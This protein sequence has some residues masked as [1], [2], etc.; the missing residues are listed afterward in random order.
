MLMTASLLLTACGGGEVGDA[1]ATSP[2]AA[3]NDTPAASNDTPT[4][5]DDDAGDEEAPAVA[6]PTAT[7]TLVERIPDLLVIHPDAFDF[8][9]SAV[10]DT[11]VYLVPMMVA[12]TAEYVLA[13]LKAL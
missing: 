9:V 4:E 2:P 6:A 13:E 7:L 10:S 11:Y 12:E 3:N 8:E 5:N 1:P